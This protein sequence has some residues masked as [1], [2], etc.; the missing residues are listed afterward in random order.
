[1]VRIV[2]NDIDDKPENPFSKFTED[3]IMNL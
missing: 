2:K 1:M 3:E